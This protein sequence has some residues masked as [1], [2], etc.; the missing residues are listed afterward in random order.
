MRPEH[1]R[2]N[3][4]LARIF[5]DQARP[6]SART[7]ATD[8]LVDYA[9][10]DSALLAELLMD[11]D[12][13]AFQLLFRVV[14]RYQDAVIPAFAH[15]LE[16]TVAYSRDDLALDPPAM[17]IDPAAMGRIES[18][19]GLL[20]DHFAFCQ[21]LPLEDFPALAEMMRK[22]GYRPIRVRPFFDRLTVRVAAVWTRDGRPWKSVQEVSRDEIRQ[23]DEKY[24]SEGYLPVD[25]AGYIATDPGGK[26]VDRY[27]A[28]WVEGTGDDRA[29]LYV[30][31]VGEE[32]GTVLNKLKEEGLSPRTLQAF[33]GSRGQSSHCGVWGQALRSFAKGQVYRDQFEGSFEQDLAAQCEQP[34]LDVAV[35]AATSGS[36]DSGPSQAE[37]ETAEG[38]AQGKSR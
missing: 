6:A 38:Q 29:R 36:I 34:L 33:V 13:Q 26:P 21:T 14:E 27:A 37:L 24:R 32:E 15:E 19:H 31:L 23:R 28:I 4:P 18:A 25:V 16:K 22:S 7:L 5:R 8:I 17:T 10:D 12:P 20:N 9:S 11:S 3:L 35:W 2:L 1:R 30:G